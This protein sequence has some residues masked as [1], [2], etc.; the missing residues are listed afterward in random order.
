MKKAF[1]I[2]CLQQP[3]KVHS[4]LGEEPAGRKGE[5]RNEQSLPVHSATIAEVGSS[6]NEG[7]SRDSERFTRR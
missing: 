4:L 7:P 2:I 1:G 6:V 3:V 5:Q